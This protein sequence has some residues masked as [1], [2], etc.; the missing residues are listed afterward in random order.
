MSRRLP[1]LLCALALAGCVAG[2]RAEIVRLDD[3]TILGPSGLSVTT[4]NLGGASWYGPAGQFSGTLDG[5]SFVTYCVD[6]PQKADFGVSYTVYRPVDGVTAFGA[7][8]AGDLAR[9]ISYVG[10][11]PRWSTESAMV[12]A[13]VWEV[14]HETGRDYGFTSGDVRA[15]GLDVATQDW[16]DAFDWTA[17]HATVATVS[18]GALASPTNQD[19]LTVS[20]VPEPGTYALLALG[21]GLVAAVS[22]RRI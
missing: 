5:A 11:S 12:Q 3:F 1:S 17:V 20:P 4:S 13:A 9:L 7:E 14:V 18:V 21:L 16:L 15:S 8:K 19:F 22:R 2:L 6:L 10:M